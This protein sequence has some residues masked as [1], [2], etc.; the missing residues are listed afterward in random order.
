[1]GVLG[2]YH[3]L[4]DQRGKS[5][6]LHRNECKRDPTLTAAGEVPVAWDASDWSCCFHPALVRKK[7]KPNKPPTKRINP[8]GGIFKMCGHASLL[9]CVGSYNTDNKQV[10]KLHPSNGQSLSPWINQALFL[11]F[12]EKP[13]NKK[14]HVVHFTVVLFGGRYRQKDWPDAGSWGGPGSVSWL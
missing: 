11:H 3:T 4:Q 5:T 2:C 1:M 9:L 12:R 14:A 6:H 10:A 8:T 7:P 13:G